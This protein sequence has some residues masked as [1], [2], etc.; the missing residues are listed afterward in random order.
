MRRPEPKDR[1]KEDE[2]ETKKSEVRKEGE[3]VN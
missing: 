3:R 2:T 1:R